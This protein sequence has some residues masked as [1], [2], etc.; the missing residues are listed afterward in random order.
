M[1]AFRY[2]L[3]LFSLPAAFAS[4]GLRL[5]DPHGHIRQLVLQKSEVLVRTGQRCEANDLRQA[6]LPASR[7]SSCLLGSSCRSDWSCL[8]L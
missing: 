5:S 3:R 8:E 6:E 7:A 2:L 1:M 4:S